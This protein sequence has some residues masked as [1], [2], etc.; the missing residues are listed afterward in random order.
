VNLHPLLTVGVQTY[1]A[2]IKF[3]CDDATPQGLNDVGIQGDATITAGSFGMNTDRPDPSKGLTGIPITPTPTPPDGVPG[4][5]LKFS[6]ALKG[7]GPIDARLTVTN[8]SQQTAENV[9]ITIQMTRGAKLVNSFAPKIWNVGTIPPGESR[10]TKVR[11]QTND[12]WLAAD[13][14][15]SIKLL[16]EV[17]NETAFPQYS[18]GTR[19]TVTVLNP[20][21]CLEAPESE[22]APLAAAPPSLIPVTHTQP[23]NPCVPEIRVD[24]ATASSLCP[25]P[26]EYYIEFHVDFENYLPNILEGQLVFQIAG[27]GYSPNYKDTPSELLGPITNYSYSPNQQLETGTMDTYMCYIP[28]S[29]SSWLLEFRVTVF[30]MEGNASTQRLCT[31]P[32]IRTPGGTTCGPY[33]CP[34]P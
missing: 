13:A 19:A 8:T 16:A 27:P 10:S 17:T 28:L 4:L 18:V 12:L 5:S 31:V 32:D 23:R 25:D 26:S 14:G 21:N 24:E 34:S 33:T 3:G 9:V 22:E 15:T 30:D 6:G 2:K 11:I 29:A 20:G 7:C 1:S